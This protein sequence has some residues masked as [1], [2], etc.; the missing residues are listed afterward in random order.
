MSIKKNFLYSTILTVANYIFPLL[1]YPYVSRVLGVCN[2]GI[3]NFVDSIINFFILFSMMG[4]GA[5]GIREIAGTAPNTNRQSKVFSSLLTL[6]GI[7]TLVMLLLLL[8]CIYIIPEFREHQKLMYIGAAK[9]VANLFLVEWFFKGTENFKYITNRTILVK[10]LYVASV[11]LFVKDADD[12]PVYFLL[13]ALMVIVNAVINFIYACS[14][15]TLSFKKINIIPYIKPFLIMG[16]YM[17]LTSMYTSL[18]VTYLGFVAGELQVGY[19][20]TATKIFSII[21]AIYSA[22]TNVMMPRMSSLYADG[23]IDEFKRLINK[24]LDLLISLSVP[25]IIFTMIYTPEIIS[26]ISGEGYEGAFLP[27]K[28]IMPLIFI[29]GYEQVLVIQILMPAKQDKLV[30]YNSIIGALVGILLNILIVPHLESIGSAITWICAEIVILIIA[31]IE[32]K[33]LIDLTFPVKRIIKS[34]LSYIPIV[35]LCLFLK[36]HF[37]GHG[38]INLLIGILVMIVYTL[39]I[40]YFIEKNNIIVSCIK[41]LRRLT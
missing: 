16:C 9:L 10:C 25:A 28:I 8:T 14:K 27:A 22:F 19:Y 15:V 24:S 35:I 6:N 17:L 32:V 36:Y 11:F 40:L 26:L 12:Y 13:L 39:G 3:C 30:L 38:N 29:I 41:M 1:T 21:L 20:T 31:S 18:N 33:R 2:I 7:S 5:V 23:N 37:S 34:I 4:V